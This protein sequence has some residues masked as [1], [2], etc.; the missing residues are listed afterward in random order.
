MKK[1]V[2]LSGGAERTGN[3]GERIVGVPPNQ[4]HSANHDHQNYREHDRI[5][6]NI[7]SL[8][9][10]ENFAKKLHHRK[11]SGAQEQISGELV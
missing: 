8:I 6:S 3:R 5:F 11:S 10:R 2:T 1:G 7:L 4:T 9:V